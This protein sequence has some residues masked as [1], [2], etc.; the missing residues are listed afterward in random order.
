MAY[1]LEGA[2][3]EIGTMILY[4]GKELEVVEIDDDVIRV[5]LDEG[6]Q[7]ATGWMWIGKGVVVKEAENISLEL[8]G[9]NIPVGMKAYYPLFGVFT[10]LD[11]R[12]QEGHVQ[13]QMYT[14]T[15]HR[16][17]YV[18]ET[19]LALRDTVVEVRNN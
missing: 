12:M 19:M 18:E 6:G 10:V 16:W 3:P 4:G 2:A 13:V 1:L 7:E 9:S 14:G 17:L 5:R 8:F 11:T 15:D